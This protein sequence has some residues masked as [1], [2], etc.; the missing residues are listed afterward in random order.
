MESNKC[1][2][3]CTVAYSLGALHHLERRENSIQLRVIFHKSAYVQN[4][5]INTANI[6]AFL[7]NIKFS[8]LNCMGAGARFGYCTMDIYLSLPAQMHCCLHWCMA[9]CPSC[10]AGC[11]THVYMHCKESSQPL[12]REQP[13]PNSLR[14][15]TLNSDIQF[16]LKLMSSM[17]V[18]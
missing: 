14:H 8:S 7:F 13:E 17:K 10:M 3:S 2:G 16:N 18:I 1:F 11:M 6:T 15:P 12:S 4:R 5:C 9:A